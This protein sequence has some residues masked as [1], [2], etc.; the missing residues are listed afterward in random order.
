[1][2]SEKSRA[3]SR[4]ASYRLRRR[5]EGGPMR[6]DLALFGLRL[7][8]SRSQAERAIADGA[9]LLNGM[10]VKPS[11]AVRPG[12]R[13]VLIQGPARRTLEVL[14]LPDRSMSRDAARALVRETEEA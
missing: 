4:A 3:S 14:A 6:F 10:V 7:F 9:V 12:D 13:V 8:K 5:I 11:R 2:V 1:M